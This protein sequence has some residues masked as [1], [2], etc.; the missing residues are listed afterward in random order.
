MK[1]RSPHQ[2]THSPTHPLTH[3]P[4]HPTP[5]TPCNERSRIAITY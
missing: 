1:K 4:T 3:S 5:H 2:V